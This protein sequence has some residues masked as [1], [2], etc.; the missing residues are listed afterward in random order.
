MK[1][2]Y[3]NDLKKA[4][5]ILETEEGEKEDY[6]IVML[7]ENDIEGLLKTDVRNVNNR[8]HYYYDIS[9]KI[10]PGVLGWNNAGLN[11]TKGNKISGTNNSLK[12]E[13]F[14]NRLK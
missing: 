8:S 11:D 10:C 4:F 1:T 6:Q 13:E 3:K 5:L 14:K 2:F 7:Q 12:W 9:G